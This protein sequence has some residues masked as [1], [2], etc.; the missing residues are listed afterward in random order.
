M[1]TVF[2]RGLGLIGS[3]LAR[4]I[5]LGHP[6]TTIVASDT[7]QAALQYACQH[8][9]IDEAV[10]NLQGASEADFIILATPVSQI[11][12]DL[13]RLA[14]L[15]LKSNVVVT[16]TGSTKQ[17]IMKAAQELFTKSVDFIGGH[18][19][20]GSHLTGVQAGRADLFHNADYFLIPTNKTNGKQR[21][22]ELLK[23]AGVHWVTITAETHDRLVAQISHLPHI[24][25]YS[26]VNQSA[27]ALT[28]QHPGLDA[29][30]GGF[31]STTRIAKADPE[32]WTA[33]MKNNQAAISHQL[34]E[35]IN[36]LEAVKQAIDQGKQQQLKAY[37]T[38]AQRVRQQLD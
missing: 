8:N 26:L 14:T 19:M 9:I 25:A 3:S 2:I 28:D 13:H 6:K 27:A 29:A 20:A 37:F 21:L 12:N 10:P 18:P 11:V 17:T 33:I 30:A 38:K 1:T 36:E 5:K 34:D 24:I 22:E 35:Y 7:N 16:D 32:M 4:I 31:K 23:S 15:P